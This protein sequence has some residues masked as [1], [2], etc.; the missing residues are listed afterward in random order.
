[1]FDKLK[2]LLGCFKHTM[3]LFMELHDCSN[4]KFLQDIMMACIILRNMIIEDDNM[5]IED[6]RHLNGAEGLI[7][8]N[9]MELPM[10]QCH[11]IIRLNLRSSL[12]SSSN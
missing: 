2:G 8:S 7:M 5:I 10:T 4:L 11:I 12:I 1:M 9:L 3:Q 6:E